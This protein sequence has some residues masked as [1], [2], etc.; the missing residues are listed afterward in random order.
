MANF[1]NLLNLYF[2]MSENQDEFDSRK[3]F[4]SAL[5]MDVIILLMI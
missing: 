2:P 4:E 5:Y 3:V 1:I